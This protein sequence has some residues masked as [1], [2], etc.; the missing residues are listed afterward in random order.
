MNIGLLLLRLGVGLTMSAHGTQK[1]F[2][3]FGGHGLDG[4]GKFMEML[5]FRPGRRNALVAGL[6]E[7][8]G[9]LLLALGLL[10]PFAA[11]AI[12][13]VMLVA[14]LVVHRPKGFFVSNGGFEYNL[15]L[16]LAALSLAFSG[17]GLYSLDAVFGLPLNGAAWGGA[18]LVA[19]LGG[20]GIQLLGRAL[21]ARNSTPPQGEPER[22]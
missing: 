22:A 11:A 17:A 8:G 3:W 14:S 16:G 13:A 15:V 4:T 10:T 1:L 5:G 7:L 2:G 21:R 6:A 19:G 9:G 12:V 20:A 18:A